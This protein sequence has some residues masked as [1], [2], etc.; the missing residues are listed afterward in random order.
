VVFLKYFVFAL[1][2][3]SLNI[4]VRETRKLQHDLDFRKYLPAFVIP[5]SELIN[6]PDYI[7]DGQT[8]RAVLVTPKCTNSIPCWIFRRIGSKVW[9]GVIEVLACERLVT[10]CGFVHGD[11]VEL[12]LF[13][14]G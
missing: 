5:K 9:E 4:D 10:K 13:Q 2:A 3:G 14:G 1:F 7:G 6:M 12:F 11:P 8:W